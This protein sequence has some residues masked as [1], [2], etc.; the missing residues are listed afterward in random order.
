MRTHDLTPGEW[1]KLLAYREEWYAIGSATGPADRFLAQKHLTNM[2]A[3]LNKPEPQY[4]WVESPAS[5]CLFFLCV[6]NQDCS[7]WA[8]L[9]ASL[10]AS[11]GASL[12][13][14]LGGSHE[15]YWIAYFK[16]ARDVLGV[17]YKQDDLSLLLHWEQISRSC[18]WLWPYDGLCVVSDRPIVQHVDEQRRLHC[19]TGPAMAFADGYALW[20]WHG[21]L[22]SQRLIEK[23][24]TITL[25]DI[26][27]E[28]NIEVRRVMIERFGWDRFLEA[29]KADLIA[30]DT[31]PIGPPGLRGL[32]RSH[33][34]QR[35]LICCC[36]SSGDS[37]YLEVPP[38]IETCQ[39]AAN[40][41]ANT[42]EDGL[43]HLLCQ[44]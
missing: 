19:E 24:Q 9:R 36:A 22:V 42:D 10:R 17:Q 12:R 29:R 3:H 25:D 23:P 30:M 27:G 13:A 34:G 26:F 40:W 33:D 39:Q 2:Y 6:R 1:E 4:L 14:S 32:F 41:L 44:T 5:A 37:Y 43:K 15:S 35:V 16:F 31:E 18:G 8:S 11:L 21:A 38:E 20:S 7:K 28:K